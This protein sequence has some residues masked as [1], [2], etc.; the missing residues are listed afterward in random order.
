LTHIYSGASGSFADGKNAQFQDHNHTEKFRRNQVVPGDYTT[1]EP[2]QSGGTE[3]VH[4]GGAWN[5]AS[6]KSH[7]FKIT[8]IWKKIDKVKRYFGFFSCAQPSAHSN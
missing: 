4:Q 3:I 1:S 7:I 6:P 8:N 5:Q 2:I